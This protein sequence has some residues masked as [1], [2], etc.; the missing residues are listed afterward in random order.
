M[1]MTID[2][3][4]DSVRAVPGAR[5]AVM[6]LPDPLPDG[7]KHERRCLRFSRPYKMMMTLRPQD[8]RR[9]T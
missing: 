6:N 4:D 7:T 3:T 8:E 2:V 1:R 5:P 9:F